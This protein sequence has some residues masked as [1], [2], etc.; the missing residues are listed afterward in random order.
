MSGSKPRTS[1]RGKTRAPRRRK[2]GSGEQNAADRSLRK[3]GIRVMGNMP[4]G[5]HICLFYETE[6]DLLDTTAAYFAAGLRSNE[7]CLWA[8]SDPITETNAKEALSFAV[9]DLDQHLAAG[10]IE[11]VPGS[12]WYLDGDQFD[13]KRVTGGWNEKLRRA[14]AKGYDGMRISGNAFWVETNHWKAFFEYEEDLDRSLADQEMIVLCTYPLHRSRAADVLDV[15][16]VHRGCAA[17]RNGDWELLET[18]EL[19]Q[20]KQ[21]IRKLKGALDIL[22]KP[23]SGYASLTPRE[24]AAL[25]QIVMGASNKEVARALGISPRTV[26][27]HRANVMRKLGARN[28]ADLVRRVVG[29]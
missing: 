20:A 16:R 5:A 12:E 19:R 28:V 26:E 18:P 15:A 22:S 23:F 13:L 27:F 17:R 25:A 3:T 14:L 1:G 8:I 2:K 7:C 29:E 24:R 9:P 4:W 21:E 11:I 6:E 10:R